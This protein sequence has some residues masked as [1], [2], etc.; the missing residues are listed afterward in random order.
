MSV[1]KKSWGY[2]Q[3]LGS[4]YS[5]GCTASPGLFLQVEVSRAQ[6]QSA[7]ILMVLLLALV[8]T[9][10]NLYCC[11]V[12]LLQ[13]LFLKCAPTFSFGIFKFQYSH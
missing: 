3:S 2:R 9:F 8:N 5:W 12:C 10:S 1:G 6:Q 13:H 7:T 11:P 4:L